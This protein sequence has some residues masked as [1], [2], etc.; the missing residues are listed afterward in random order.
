MW[1]GRVGV[2]GLSSSLT[3]GGADALEPKAPSTSHIISTGYLV[4]RD[5][6]I[7][8]DGQGIYSPGTGLQVISLSKVNPFLLRRAAETQESQDSNASRLAL[9]PV[10][11]LL[12]CTARWRTVVLSPRGLASGR[13]A[14][15]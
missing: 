2:V 1:L 3:R 9:G 15:T 10:L 12:S 13:A 6:L 5:T 7:R 8:Q 4:N 11:Q 14:T